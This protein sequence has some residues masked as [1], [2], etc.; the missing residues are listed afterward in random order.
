MEEDLLVPIVL[1]VVE[2][3]KFK[4]GESLQPVAE[5]E[6]YSLDHLFQMVVEADHPVVQVVD[7]EVV[8]LILQEA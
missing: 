4:F 1:N 2:M 7:P 3:G 5:V 6:A 8:E